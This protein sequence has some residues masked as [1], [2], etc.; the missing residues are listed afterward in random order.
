MSLD[1]ATIDT[2]F[3]ASETPMPPRAIWLANEERRLSL[4]YEGVAPEI[5]STRALATHRIGTIRSKLEVGAPAYHAVGGAANI[6]AIGRVRGAPQR[7]GWLLLV[8][9]PT[10]SLEVR[11]RATL[12]DSV[13][14]TLA[15][16]Q[17]DVMLIGARPEAAAAGLWV[18]GEQP[19]LRLVGLVDGR[20]LAATPIAANDDIVNPPLMLPGGDGRLD[21]LVTRLVPEHIETSLATTGLFRISMAP[22]CRR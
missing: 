7:P 5:P 21:L 1:G 14:Q 13:G 4:T 17:S 18:D 10:G 11:Y 9:T 19:P 2:Q 16:G 15:L 22:I 6:L 12:A 8:R 3:I 20:A